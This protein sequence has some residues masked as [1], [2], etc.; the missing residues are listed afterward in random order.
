[1]KKYGKR[2][3]WVRLTGVV[4]AAMMIASVGAMMPIENVYAVPELPTGD[5]YQTELIEIDPPAVIY[6]RQPARGASALAADQTDYSEDVYASYVGYYALDESQK[7]VYDA[8]KK[9]A[10]MCYVSDDPASLV[11][12]VVYNGGAGSAYTFAEIP[13]YCYELTPEEVWETFNSFRMDNP[14]YFFT[15]YSMLYST[16]SGQ[17]IVYGINLVIDDELTN[18]DTFIETRQVIEKTISSAQ[19]EIEDDAF[20]ITALNS[21]PFGNDP[22][23]EATHD[24]I[25]DRIDYAFDENNTPDQS[26]AAHSITGVFGPTAGA[27]VCEGYA[28]SF[29]LLLNSFDIP[30]IYVTGIGNGGGHAWSMAQMN[31]GWFYYF[32]LTWDDPV[33]G[34]ERKDYFAGG[35][36][37]FAEE[38]VLDNSDG[39]GKDYLYDL[40]DVPDSNYEATSYEEYIED[41]YVYRL[42]NDHAALVK[43]YG[44][45]DLNEDHAV[46]PSEVKGLPVT[47]I[48]GAFAGISNLK[49]VVIPDTVTTLSYGD[50]GIGAFEW[51]SSLK[52]VTLPK[53]LKRID[54]HSFY[55]CSAL[56]TISIPSSV[57]RIG[58]SIFTYCASLGEIMIYSK[59]C[60]IPRASSICEK[61]VIYGYSGSTAQIYAETYNRTF[62]MLSDLIL[63]TLPT[64]ITTTTSETE[65]TTLS[66][67]TG[68]SLTIASISSSMTTTSSDTHTTAMATTSSDQVMTTLISTTLPEPITT[69]AMTSA[70]MQTTAV[71]PELI[72]DINRDGISTL[73]DLVILNLYILGDVVDLPVN[74]RVIDCYFDGVIDTRDSA[75]LLQFLLRMIDQLP[76]YP[77]L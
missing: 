38:H 77:E 30:N 3:I 59:N 7:A 14:I 25:I 41:R 62:C 37:L 72:S 63:T 52:N 22:I 20:R 56:E 67:T 53:T 8:I 64:M 66:S 36:T 34:T 29:Q 27:A 42:Y 28:K 39:S 76:V 10:H 40:P 73:S 16:L 70:T 35:R 46:V 49:S 68:S 11:E 44:N 60:E 9:E 18:S 33:G 55:G 19:E 74:E 43:Y 48:K 17:D 13:I 51:C 75:V 23:I 2:E 6:D 65:A 1:M 21:V 58:E 31:D 69:A 54:Y 50:N 47:E 15:S 45:T 24:W 5:V 71:K 57:A 12:T 32:D 4:T 61:P 26:L